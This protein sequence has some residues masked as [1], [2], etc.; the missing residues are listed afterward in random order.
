MHTN[1]DIT[2]KKVK[3]LQGSTKPQ[4]NYKE[5]NVLLYYIF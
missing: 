3:S 1:V 2:N 5:I 4:N